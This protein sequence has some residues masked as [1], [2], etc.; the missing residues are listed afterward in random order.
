MT[1]TSDPTG[2]LDALAG[3]DR[4]LIQQVFRPIGNEYR[5]SI[6]APGS[7]E[8]GAPLL[9]IKQ[10]RLSIREDI[11][12]RL[13]PDRDE[14]LF[15]IKARTVFEFRGRHDVLDA[16]GVEIGLLEKDFARSLVRSHWHVRDPAGAELFE[17]YE[18]S[19]P[20]AIVRRIAG[21]LPEIF[22]ILTWLPF[23]FALMRGGDQVGSYRRVLGKLRDRYV[24]E[25]EPGLADV[26]RRLVLALAIGLD[27]LQD[28]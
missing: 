21:L 24:L 10:K 28:R 5:I 16:D 4:L 17:G 14:H 13:D 1:T 9:F 11:R 23:H 26:D 7:S 22:S 27:A 19:W 15:M 6:P 3:S 12:F 8:E 18:A 20:I 2:V 25:I